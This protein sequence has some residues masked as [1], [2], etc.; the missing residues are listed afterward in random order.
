[1]SKYYRLFII[2]VLF[3]VSG[4]ATI[5]N[6]TTQKISVSSDPSGANFAVVG[7]NT[8]FTTPCQVE[9]SRKSDHI[10]KFQKKGY[11]SA[12]V[13]VRHV[14]SGAVAGNI[15]AGGLIGWGVDAASGGQYR[16]VPDAI[17]VTLKPELQ[18]PATLLNS[19]N[20]EGELNKLEQM[21]KD[22]MINHSEYEK[23]R[24]KAIKKF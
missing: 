1:M 21:R 17:N 6:G 8:N 9:L 18:P 19:K 24:K 16:L 23:L 22:N 2:V 20:L 7:E 14:I 10:L 12:T 11:Y 15:L 3:C 4:C 5:I 13:D